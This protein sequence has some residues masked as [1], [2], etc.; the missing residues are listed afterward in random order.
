MK[1]NGTTVNKKGRP[2]MQKINFDPKAAKQVILQ[3]QR[4]G[5][6]EWEK[7]YEIVDENLCTIPQLVKF[8]QMAIVLHFRACEPSQV[9]SFP[10]LIKKLL[11]DR[12]DL[13]F[14]NFFCKD[15]SSEWYFRGEASVCK[16]IKGH[17]FKNCFNFLSVLE[18]HFIINEYISLKRGQ[19]STQNN[20]NV[21]ETKNNENDQNVEEIKNDENVEKTSSVSD[22]DIELSFPFDQ[23]PPY[24]D[25]LDKDKAIFEQLVR[26]NEF[27]FI[28]PRMFQIMIRMKYELIQ[29]F[30]QI[31]EKVYVFQFW[32]KDEIN[33]ILS[34]MRNFGTM[35]PVDEIH[36]LSGLLSKS[37]SQVR[38]IAYNLMRFFN[39]RTVNN[40][41][42]IPAALMNNIKYA[43]IP[44]LKENLFIDASDSN[45][46]FKRI[47]I[48]SLMKKALSIINV[49]FSNDEKM[50]EVVDGGKDW[51]T[52]GHSKVFFEN[53]LKFGLDNLTSILL[54]PDLIFR[55]NLADR[56]IEILTTGIYR[57]PSLSDENKEESKIPSFLLND[58]NFYAF[59]RKICGMDEILNKNNDDAKADSKNAASGSSHKHAS[60]KTNVE[61]PKK[62]KIRKQK[63]S[64][65]H[66]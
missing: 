50:E 49:K 55:K 4:V 36:P 60:S 11:S 45:I 37:P 12:P 58:N 21:E 42:I 7:I 30:S 29:H 46:L 40:A 22:S 43:P 26:T 33:S 48:I 3:L 1:S 52:L 65:F 31:E 62:K 35:I 10:L 15:P 47:C 13:E 44:S 6:G 9:S 61:K 64:V 63:N 20:E 17:I 23:L 41:V 27:S 57:A 56:D 51:W 34:M 66:S 18:F 39:E 8:C 19:L 59:L 32:T 14:V 2:V 54:S 38:L 24:P 16:L 28:N 5:Y 25:Y 53:L